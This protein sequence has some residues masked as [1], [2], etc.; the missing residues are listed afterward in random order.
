[1]FA[2]TLKTSLLETWAKRG[3]FLTQVTFMIVND[4]VFVAFWFLFFNRVGEVRGWDAGR[5]LTLLAILATVTGIALGLCANARHLGEIISSNQ[6]DAVLPLPV[7]PLAYLLARR[8]DTAL[9][10]DLLFGPILFLLFGEPTMLR[11]A[12]YVLVSLCGA[13]VLISFLLVLGSLTFFMGGRGE[14]TELGFQAVLILSAYPIDLFTGLT[15]VIMFTAVPAAFVSGLP[16]RLV[17]DF[18]WSQAALLFTV[19]VVFVL[20]ARA[21]FRAGL[22]RYRSGATWSRA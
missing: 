7:D 8:I 16:T 21:L 20:G 2:L 3:S 6:L 4:L 5:T 22:R 9:L 18:S 13:A 19:S 1:M 17:D 14:Q 15:R 12:I 11:T 10:G